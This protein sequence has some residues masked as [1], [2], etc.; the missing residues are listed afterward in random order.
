[1]KVIIA[2]DNA[3]LRMSGETA[4]PL[5][6]FDRFRD[7][8]ID[9]W[10]IC[11]ERCKAELRERYPDDAVFGRIQ[12]MRDTW[13][14]IN[15]FRCTR[16][17]PFRL[18]DQIVTQMLRWLTDLQVRPAVKALIRE[19][20][21]ELVFQPTPIAA[22]SV[23]MMYGLGVPVVLGPMCGGVDFPPAFREVD[24]LTDRITMIVGRYAAGLL[25][26]LFPGKRQA[27]VLLVA[28]ERTRRALPHGCRGRVYEVVE[29]GVD[30]NL[31]KP[32]ERP[33]APASHPTRFVYMARFIGQKGIPYLIEAFGLVAVK[34]GAV[35]ELI[36]DGELFDAMRERASALGVADR[37][38]FHGRM[39]LEAAKKLIAESDVY[40]VPSIGDCGGLAMLEAMAIGMP[41]IAANWAG[42]GEYADEHCGILV[43]LPS[44]EAFVTGLAAAM[45][46][47][48][49][50]PDLRRRLGAGS[51]RRVKTNYF[52]W[53]SKA[54]RVLQIFAD[55][56]SSSSARAGTFNQSRPN[57]G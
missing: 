33:P 20:G 43:D 22:K 41:V 15:L 35:L 39:T 11:H 30:L 32:M 7:R 51:V 47:L 27:D 10:M 2:A 4:I 36:G 26:R 45:M 50:S 52:D 6:F 21:A 3:S 31:W 17:L 49:E 5:Y 54:D 25:N 12:F 23:S 29:S 46:R 38:N 19:H 34:S 53:D 42:P 48:A 14:Q 40:V 13:L 24:S 28:N 44:R 56:L 37:V 18:R 16:W 55:V 9:V 8:C 57:A 1:M